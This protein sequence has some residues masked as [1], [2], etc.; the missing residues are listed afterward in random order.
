[1]AGMIYLAELRFFLRLS[2]LRKPSPLAKPLPSVSANAAEMAPVL[3]A[4]PLL[5]LD[6]MAKSSA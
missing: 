1:M 6:A 2:P 5:R 3:A 4:R